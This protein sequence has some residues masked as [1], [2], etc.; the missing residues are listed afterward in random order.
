LGKELEG[1]I[2]GLLQ[3]WAGIGLMG[4]RKTKKMLGISRVLPFSGKIED[5]SA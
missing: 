3:C 1:G 5:V 4:L 2:A